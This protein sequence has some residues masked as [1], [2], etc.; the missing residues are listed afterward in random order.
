[1][2]LTADLHPM[3]DIEIWKGNQIA[4]SKTSKIPI[5]MDEDGCPTEEQPFPSLIKILHRLGPLWEHQNNDWGQILGRGPDGW[6]YFF[7]NKE[8]QWA[9][10]TIEMPLP[11][12]LTK[13]LTYLRALMFS[14]D[15]GQ[16]AK[17]KLK[18]TT[19]PL[20]D[21]PITPRW[22]HILEDYWLLLPVTQFPLSLNTATLQRSIKSSALK[23]ARPPAGEIAGPQPK[24]LLHF[25]SPRQKR[26]QKKEKRPRKKIHITKEPLRGSDSDA[27]HAGF[28]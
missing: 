15:H 8:L 28:A 14:T 2:L 7:G 6:H 24:L 1:M 27:A 12:P 21:L 13:A 22:R 18:I 11:H 25:P 9:N 4:N 17:L 5:T 16:W 3:G 26:S 10:P 19:S 23:H 20:G